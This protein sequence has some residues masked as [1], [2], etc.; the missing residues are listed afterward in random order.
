MDRAKPETGDVGL[1][2]SGEQAITKPSA[3]QRGTLSLTIPRQRRNAPPFD[4]G[5][6]EGVAARACVWI[7]GKVDSDLSGSAGVVRP[8]C[9]G[10][11]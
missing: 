3:S 6:A 8:S 1:A 2:G 9:L 4:K 11:C 7:N 10:A 5:D